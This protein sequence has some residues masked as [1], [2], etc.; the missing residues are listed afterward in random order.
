MV[1]IIQT[2]EACLVVG[3]VS[4]EA[5]SV[6]PAHHDVGTNARIGFLAVD[7]KGGWGRQWVNQE[8]PTLTGLREV[9]TFVPLRAV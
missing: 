8:H 5:E 9:S 7:L 2:A 1:F 3:E 4:V 6:F